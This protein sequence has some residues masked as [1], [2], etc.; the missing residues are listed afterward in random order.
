MTLFCPSFLGGGPE[1]ANGFRVRIDQERLAA[2]LVYP[3]EPFAQNFLL[4]PK[5]I[6]WL[7][8]WGCVM[9]L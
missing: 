7:C 1:I 2:P 8:P 4:R 3:T 9:K 5:R 6:I